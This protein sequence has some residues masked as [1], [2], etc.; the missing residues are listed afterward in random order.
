MLYLVMALE[1]YHIFRELLLLTP[2]VF[3]EAQEH[4]ISTHC[5]LQNNVP[6]LVW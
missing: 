3:L 1:S 4:C 6:P 2:T 5:A